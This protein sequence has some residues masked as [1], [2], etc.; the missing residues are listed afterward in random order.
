MMNIS[1]KYK[2]DTQ[3]NSNFKSSWINCNEQNNT[4]L[5]FSNYPEYNIKNDKSEKI[6]NSILKNWTKTSLRELA[7]PMIN[8]VIKLSKKYSLEEDLNSEVSENI[9]EMF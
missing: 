4:E 5:L 6:A 2:E 9:Y 3:D 7:T 8:D 1:K